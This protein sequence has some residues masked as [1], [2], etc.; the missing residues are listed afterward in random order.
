MHKNRPWHHQIPEVS[1]LMHINSLALDARVHQLQLQDARI[2][3]ARV[4]TRRQA[5]RQRQHAAA[6]QQTLEASEHS[7]SHLPA[8]LCAC[9]GPGALRA[10]GQRQQLQLLP[11]QEHRRRP[12]WQPAAT[13]AAGFQQV[14]RCSI[15]ILE[16]RSLLAGAG[17]QGSTVSQAAAVPPSGCHAARSDL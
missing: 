8:W 15:S 17:R 10:A 6:H 13:A 11:A 14:L 12:S 7:Y 9:P 3:T 5:G 4:R 1:D 16:Q 2:S